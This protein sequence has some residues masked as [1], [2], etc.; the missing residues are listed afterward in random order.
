MAH[1]ALSDNRWLRF[2]SFSALYAAQGIPDAMVLIIFPAYLAA[3]G[4]SAAYIGVFLAT[5]ML[6]NSA[7]LLV[8]PLIDR[9]AYLPMGRRRPWVMFGQIGIAASFLFLAFIGEPSENLALFS[10]GTFA[11]TLSAVFQDVATDGMVMDM[12]PSQ[13]QGQANGIMWG[14]KTLG[15]AAAGAGGAAI[16]AFVGFAA[17]ALSAASILLFVFAFVILVRERTSE[18][19]LPWTKGTAS[20]KSV[21]THTDSWRILGDQ[22]WRAIRRPAAIRLIAISICIGLIAGLTG[23]LLPVLLV[24][25]FG[26]VDTDYSQFRSTLKLIAGV[27]GIVVGGILVDRMG[28]RRTLTIL[29]ATLAMANAIMASTLR[30]KYGAYY[31]SAFELLLV[32]IF[33]AF[34]AATMKQSW[35]TIAATQFSFTMVC[36]NIALV[37]GAALLGFLTEPFGYQSALLVLSGIALIASIIASG[38]RL[39]EQLEPVITRSI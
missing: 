23:A 17:M 2:A 13:E 10:A 9:V 6:P 30:L 3:K 33:I 21:A 39:D 5:V 35:K 24:Q 8:G 12:V 7:K 20:P 34:F 18:R 11:I 38:L 26:W 4:M 32:F 25:N 27:A 29:F 1:L 36:G 15:T 22:L 31:I 14:S 28:H 19:Y 16:L 37:V